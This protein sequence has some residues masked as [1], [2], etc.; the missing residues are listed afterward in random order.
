MEAELFP[1]QGVEFAQV[2][3]LQAQPAGEQEKARPRR[4][5]SSLSMAAAAMRVRLR[6]DIAMTSCSCSAERMTRKPPKINGGSKTP[7]IRPTR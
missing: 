4:A 6:T 3:G 7:M 5:L 1:G 2:A